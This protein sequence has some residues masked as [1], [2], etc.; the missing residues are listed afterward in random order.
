VEF[1]GAAIQRNSF[2]RQRQRRFAI[3]KG[4]PYLREQEVRQCIIRYFPNAGFYQD[5]GAFPVAGANQNL[6]LGFGGGCGKSQ[7][8][9]DCNRKSSANVHRSSDYGLFTVSPY[10][11]AP[12]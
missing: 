7:A 1:C 10:F 3:P 2:F 12:T 9:G 6:G 8:D 5:L 11:T 4:I